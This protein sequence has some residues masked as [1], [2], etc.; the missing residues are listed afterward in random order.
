VLDAVDRLTDLANRASVVIHTIDPRG[1]VPAGISASDSVPNPSPDI[2]SGVLQTRH[3]T[4]HASQANLSYLAEQTG[5][6]A[7]TNTNDVDAGVARILSGS[8][9]YY[10]VGYEPERATF[11]DRP[12]FHDIEVK[13]KRRGVKVRSRKGFF[14]MTDEAVAALAPPQSF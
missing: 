8:R 5:G 11:S 7:V 4:L 12:R 14:G 6:I 13:V 3:T 1:L 2:I 9:G 10:L